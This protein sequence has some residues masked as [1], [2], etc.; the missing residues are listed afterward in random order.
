MK[1]NNRLLMIMKG[2]VYDVLGRMENKKQLLSHYIREMSD[3][4][5]NNRHQLSDLETE[6]TQIVYK[7]NKTQ[8]DLNKNKT[9]LEQALLQKR[10]KLA[11]MLR[12]NQMYCY[13]TIHILE[14]EICSLSDL[15]TRKTEQI[16]YRN[17]LLNGIMIRCRKDNPL[18]VG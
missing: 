3:E 7:L 12:T 1:W 13:D 5:Q 18:S 17:I 10:K 11:E 16:T 2:Y 14:G 4:I 15:I 8:Q 6:K 9:D